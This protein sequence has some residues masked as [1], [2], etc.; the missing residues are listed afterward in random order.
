MNSIEKIAAAKNAAEMHIDQIVGN[1]DQTPDA[2]EAR[3]SELAAMKKDE[4]IEHIL[5][6]E[7]PKTEKSFTV[8]SIAKT[9]L[10][11]STCA[12]LPYKAIAALIVSKVPDAKT[13]DKSIASYVTR[14][15][16]D[17]SVVPREKIQLTF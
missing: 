4:L 14:H 3:R 7:K 15:K 12:V 10:E 11:D 6:L 2:V 17:W 5:G 16:E 9:I 8:E 13:T 1:A